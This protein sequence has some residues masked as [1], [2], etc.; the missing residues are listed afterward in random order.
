M[1]PRDLLRLTD[2]LPRIADFDLCAVP[3]PRVVDS[4]RIRIFMVAGLREDG[5]GSGEDGGE[6]S[7]GTGEEVGGG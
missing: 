7:D 1:N 4:E 5:D 6:G 2:P 3:A